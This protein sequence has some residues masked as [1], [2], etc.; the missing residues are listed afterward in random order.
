MISVLTGNNQADLGNRLHELMG[1]FI[2]EHSELALER[3]DAEEA[4]AQAILDAVASMPFLSQRKLVIV[5]GLSSDKQA[6]EILEQIISSISDSTDLIIYEPSL[7]KR[8]AYYKRLKSVGQFE[9]Y[10]EPDARDLPKWLVGKAAELGGSLSPA[11]ANYLAERV[12]AN[13]QLLAGELEKL[14]SYDPKISRQN[15]DLLSEKSPQ[16]KVFDLLDAAFGGQKKRALTLYEEQRAARVEPQ[17]IMAM[18]A[19][20][21]RLITIA[22]LSS[23]RDAN[24]VVKDAGVSV[25]P[26]SKAQGLAAKLTRGRLRELV[27]EAERLDKLSKSK[28][29]DLD[30]A[31]RS[32]IV[33]I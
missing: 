10:V 6:L 30:E 11:D 16:S 4:G 7:D 9:E 26:L 32:Y 31:I 2:K 24:Q 5:R 13:Q 22:S 18:L 12:G 23:H 28:T 1:N 25:Y 15:I 17:F 20:Q 19:W 8:T 21:L 14:I 33:T 3:I 29:I 27:V